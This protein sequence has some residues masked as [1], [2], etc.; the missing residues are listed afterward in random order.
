MHLV[1]VG[2]RVSAAFKLRRS[3]IEGR[4]LR[5]LLLLLRLRLRSLSL[6]LSPKL[7]LKLSRL[8]LCRLSLS[9]LG[10][11]CLSLSLSL[12]RLARLL[13][14][15]PSLSLLLQCSKLIV[16]HL[17]FL[18]DESKLQLVPLLRIQHGLQCVRTLALAFRR[19]QVVKETI[20]V[21]ESDF[22][23]VAARAGWRPV[24]LVEK[25]VLAVR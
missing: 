6:S 19:G 23:R 9:R 1:G 25:L 4:H 21:V 11:C 13:L 3:R 14:P 8:G 5:L 17:V 15:F 2:R 22:E 12:T 18:V 10:L 24:V 20:V 7:S 16:Q